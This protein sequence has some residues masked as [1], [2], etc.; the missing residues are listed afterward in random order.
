MALPIRWLKRRYQQSRLSPRRRELESQLTQAWDRPIQ[1]VAASTS[2]SYDEIY[3]ALDKTE[4]VA[5]VRVNSPYRKKP[6]L[7]IADHAGYPLAA[8]ERLNLEWDTYSK[9]NPL[10]LS[11]EPLW[12]TTDAIA[13]SWLHWPRVS[14]HLI[15]NRSDF[16]NVLERILPTIQSMHNQ[17]ITHLDMNL[18]NLLVDPNSDRVAVIDFEFGPAKWITPA[19]QRGLD[20]IRLITDCSKRRRGGGLL[21]ADL[22][23]M[24]QLLD[25][26]V[27]KETRAA[28]VA[29]STVQLPRLRTNERLRSHLGEIFPNLNASAK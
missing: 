2:E 21:E 20:Y 3:Y 18:G 15:Q 13:C 17:G 22:P 28:E 4:R 12:R 16:W 11:P 25:G 29:F 1:L 10:G 27:D 19:Q 23:R 14:Q 26:F 6:D 9:L 7:V 24:V 8:Q 5:V